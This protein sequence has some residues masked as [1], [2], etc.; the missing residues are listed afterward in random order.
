MWPLTQERKLVTAKRNHEDLM[1]L[2]G[3]GWIWMD[4]VAFNFEKPPDNAL[5]SA[6]LRH[7]SQQVHVKKSQA[8]QLND[9]SALRQA[10]TGNDAHHGDSSV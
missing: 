9:Y 2:D 3:F 6:V 4:L 5:S 10:L 8:R 1:D 7:G